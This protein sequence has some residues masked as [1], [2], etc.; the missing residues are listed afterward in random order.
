LYW[1]ARTGGTGLSPF[2]LA[3]ISGINP[4]LLIRRIAELNRP[5]QLGYCTTSLL[6][7]YSPAWG[8]LQYRN[9]HQED[10]EAEF[11]NGDLGDA[12]ETQE[13]YEL[14]TLLAKYGSPRTWRKHCTRIFDPFQ[15]VRNQPT[16]QCWDDMKALWKLVTKVTKLRV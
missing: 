2:A 15:S 14:D 4:R 9:Y 16:P 13:T 1:R 7:I 11:R 3:G 8:I 6:P 10:L 5:L 12:G